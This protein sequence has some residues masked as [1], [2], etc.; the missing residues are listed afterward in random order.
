MTRLE[1]FLHGGQERG[2]MSIRME[3]IQPIIDHEYAYLM[4][5]HPHWSL[6]KGDQDLELVAHALRVL[7]H[8]KTTPQHPDEY[9][10]LVDCQHA[11]GGWGKMS[12]EKTS[13][14]WVTAFCALML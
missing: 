3:Q 8:M 13:A 2:F 6:T 10:A 14:A 12:S 9:L 5:E 4:A 7:L 1:A 11:D